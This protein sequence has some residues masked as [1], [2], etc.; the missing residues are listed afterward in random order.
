MDTIKNIND[1]K[2]MLQCDTD[3]ELTEFFHNEIYPVTFTNDDKALILSTDADRVPF[4]KVLRYPFSEAAYNDAMVGLQCVTDY[5]MHEGYDHTHKD[6]FEHIAL[7]H[8]EKIGVYE[9]SVSKHYMEYWS[10]FE[11]GFHF[12]R[13]DLNN[14]ERKELGFIRWRIKDDYTVP[15]FLLTPE[16]YTK[17][18]YFTA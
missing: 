9:Y 12:Y 5:A 3:K 8:A 11:D 1:L 17:Y 13:V 2:K 15:A 10:L 16:G 6:L 18:N 4:T 7:L 14:L